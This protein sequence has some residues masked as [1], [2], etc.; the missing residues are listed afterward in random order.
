MSAD[1]QD[2]KGGPEKAVPDVIEVRGVLIKNP[3][4]PRVAPQNR[5]RHASRRAADRP[6]SPTQ[7]SRVDGE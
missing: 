5:S 7:S 3:S 1:N 2:V 4:K 6:N